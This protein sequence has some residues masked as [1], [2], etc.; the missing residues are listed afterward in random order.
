MKTSRIIMLSAPLAMALMAA[1]ALAHGPHGGGAC[2]Q[3]FQN[4][5]GTPGSAGGFAGFV[6]CLETNKAKL[7]GPCLDRLSQMQAKITAWNECKTAVSGPP[8][9]CPNI[10]TGPGQDKDFIQ[11][12]RGLAENKSLPASCQP[13][14]AQ[15]HRHHHPC[16]PTPTPGT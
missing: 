2:R 8:D 16:H 14:L 13:L 3:E 10:T 5:C 7:T 9:L 1:P 6:T 12:L 11:C 4:L 15:H